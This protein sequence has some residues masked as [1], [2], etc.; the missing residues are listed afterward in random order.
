MT[1]YLLT[2]QLQ[3][4]LTC[5]QSG[6]KYEFLNTKKNAN[7]MFLTTKQLLKIDSNDFMHIVPLKDFFKK[8]QEQSQKLLNEFPQSKKAKEYMENETKLIQDFEADIEKSKKQ[9]K[10]QLDEMQKK[11][12]TL[13]DSMQSGAE[14]EL[15]KQIKNIE[16]HFKTLEET[17]K[18][19]QELDQKVTN[20]QSVKQYEDALEKCLNMEDNSSVIDL[21]KTANLNID[22]H[23]NF[24]GA[25]SFINQKQST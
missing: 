1:K 12:L 13:I 5:P 23:M 11:V 24:K 7:P 8:K 6:L 10:T 14:A 17:S 22:A 20:V 2:E 21:I 4:Q 15:Q 3:D 25:L 16:R 19:C 9:V 18:Q